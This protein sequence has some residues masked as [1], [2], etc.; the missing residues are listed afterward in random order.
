VNADEDLGEQP[1][2]LSF[3]M[4]YRKRKMILDTLTNKDKLSKLL[5]DERW[6]PHV[7]LI[8]LL[9]LVVFIAIVIGIVQWLFG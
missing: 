2:E 5:R 3:S 8:I 1:P 7:H 9:L 6:A 4:L